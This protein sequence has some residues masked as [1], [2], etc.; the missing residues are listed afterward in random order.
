[1]SFSLSFFV[2]LLS[3]SLYAPSALAD[4]VI[5]EFRQVA[6]GFYSGGRPE[7]EGLQEIAKLGV[8]TIINLENVPEIVEAEMNFAAS[9]SIRSFSQPMSGFFRPANENV[10]QILAL[11]AD[12]NNY[13]IFLHCQHGQDRTGL[14]VGLFRVFQQHWDPATAY[15]EML[16]HNFHENLLYPLADYFRERTG[17]YDYNLTLSPLP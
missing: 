5:P 8:K 9:L 3:F 15:Q 13:P 11:L 6:V 14:I 1:M 10:D 16:E 4:S 12:K 2:S 17:W 7:A